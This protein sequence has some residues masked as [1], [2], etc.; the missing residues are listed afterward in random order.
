[1]ARSMDMLISNNLSI[2]VRNMET[3]P[4]IV[5][6]YITY[7]VKRLN[8]KIDLRFIVAARSIIPLEVFIYKHFWI[9]TSN[10]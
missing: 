6:K 4:K 1:M 3:G 10:N 9:R 5:Q 7:P 2:L 8:R